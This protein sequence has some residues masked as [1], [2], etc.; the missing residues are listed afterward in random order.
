MPYAFL[1]PDGTIK[2]IFN[3]PSP[4]MRLGEGERMVTYDPPVHDEELEQVQPVTPVP[5][6][7]MAVE[8]EVST[9]PGVSAQDIWMRRRSAAVQ[10]LLDSEAVAH[11]YDNIVSAVSYANSGHP[12]FG[13][14]GQAFLSWRDECWQ[15]LFDVMNTAFGSGAPA[16]TEAEV[17]AAMPVFGAGA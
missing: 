3:K 13:P 7:Q 5:E 10:T 2:Q 17:V 12:V 16:P 1:N 14:E 4:F 9:K 8:F 15:K 6:L 11:G